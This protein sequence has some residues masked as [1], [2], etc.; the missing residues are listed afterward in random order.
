MLMQA[1]E[2]EHEADQAE[3]AQA[4]AADQ[5]EPETGDGG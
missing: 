2:H 3:L 1:R 5:A 4:A